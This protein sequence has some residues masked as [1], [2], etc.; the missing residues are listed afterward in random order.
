MSYQNA[1]VMGLNDTPRHRAQMQAQGFLTYTFHDS[2]E[3][4]GSTGPS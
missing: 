1:I 4:S 2:S 3:E